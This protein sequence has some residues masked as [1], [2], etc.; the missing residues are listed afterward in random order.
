MYALRH[1]FD[2]DQ[3]HVISPYLKRYLIKEL[4]TLSDRRKDFDIYGMSEPIN[5][6]QDVSTFRQS[7]RNY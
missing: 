7:I 4:G 1:R 3:C 2:C 5:R 6:I